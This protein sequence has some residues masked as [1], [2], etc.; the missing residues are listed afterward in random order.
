VQ[1]SFRAHDYPVNGNPITTPCQSERTE[2]RSADWYQWSDETFWT[3]V[4]QRDDGKPSEAG[5]NVTIP[6]H[7]NVELDESTPP[8]GTLTI[9]GRL[10]WK[11]SSVE[12]RSEDEIVLTAMR[13]VVRHEGLL[14]IRGSGPGVPYPGRARIRLVGDR[15]T[16]LVALGRTAIRASTLAVLGEVDM[17]GRAVVLPWTKLALTASAG[18]TSIT[19]QGDASAGGWRTGDEIAISTSSF[20][21]EEAETR[22]IASIASSSEA[23]DSSGLV[24][25]ITLT[26]ALSFSHEVTEASYDGETV[27]TAPEVGLLTRNIRIEGADDSL[28]HDPKDD[29]AFALTESDQ[30][31]ARVMIAYESQDICTNAYEGKAIIRNVEIVRAGHFGLESNGEGAAVAFL[32]VTSTLGNNA[33]APAPLAD[34]SFALLNCT[35]HHLYQLGAVVASGPSGGSRGVR[36]DNNVIVRSV[37]SGILSY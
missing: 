14:R 9:L 12:D 19:I 28:L 34:K 32:G 18:D 15:S 35:M 22:T 1:G 26:E 21:P 6:W 33:I 2:T 24:T 25:E 20:R 13:V 16:D 11:S 23:S 29:T 10:R 7:L 27:R 5:E 31:G 17:E 30:F 37:G 4:V 8:L 3:D 36:V